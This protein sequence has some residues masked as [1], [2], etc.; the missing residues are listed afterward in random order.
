[1]N[2]FFREMKANRKSLILWSLGIVFLI[3]VG[4]LKFQGLST[5]QKAMNE[6]L[7]SM[8]K[9]VQSIM[10][11]GT[12]DLS[13]ASGFYGILFLYLVLMAAIHAAMFG[14][15]IISKEERDKT[16]EFLYV[17]PK[18]RNEIITFKLLAA[19]ANIF[20]FNIV[21]FVMS[22]A[23]ISAVGKGENITGGMATLMV[24]M[25]ILQLMFLSIGTG[26]AALSKNP[27]TSGSIST[28]IL[29]AAFILSIM[30]DI[31]DKLEPLK[32][33]TPFKYF[34]AKN[35][36]YDKQFDS[37][38]VILSVVI[39]LVMTCITYVFYKKKDLR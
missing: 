15:N 8:P 7:A 28:G 32:Y 10:G 35:L 1:M 6:V 3:G 12:F 37:V 38:F 22:I 20:I 26:I 27:K 23:M 21:T 18:S 31:N 11:T 14:A 25:F 30:I 39:I 9:A 17:K 13:K 34:E 5:S 16:S 4:M 24:G 29:F 2:I 19:L 36:M 33:L